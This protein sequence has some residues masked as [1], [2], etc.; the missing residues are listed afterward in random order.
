MGENSLQRF[1]RMDAHFPAKVC[2]DS[3]G[4]ALFLEASPHVRGNLAWVFPALVSA[5]A[6]RPLTWSLGTGHG[7]ADLEG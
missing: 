4:L 2:C 7:G 5:G 6:A 3:G 1:C